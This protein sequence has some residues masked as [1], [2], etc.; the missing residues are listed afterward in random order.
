MRPTLLAAAVALAMATATASHAA[1]DLHSGTDA[2]GTVLAAG[3]LDPF[4]TISTDGTTFTAARVAY[5]GAYPDFGSGQTCCGMD[6][7][8]ATAAWITTPDVIATSPST[9]WGMGNTVYA[10][11]SF[12]LSTYELDT[13]A[14]TGK[15]R[16]ADT[17]M[18]VYLNGHLLGGTSGLGMTFDS[19]HPFSV[20]AGSGWFVAGSNTLEMRGTSVNSVW[21]AFWLSTTVTGNPAP[22]PEPET[23]ALLIG[24]LALVGAV[25]RHRR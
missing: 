12:D 1:I 22:V 5:P 7:V 8:D 17:A 16:V 6:T 13:V 18:G 4:W 3:T 19:D 15:F 20:A 10:R 23:W 21:D 11:R 14:L 24:G 9:S 25:T 2:A